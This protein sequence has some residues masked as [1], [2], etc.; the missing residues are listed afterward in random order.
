MK[1]YICIYTGTD[2]HI[3]LASGAKDQSSTHPNH[4]IFNYFV[5]SGGCNILD[6]FHEPLMNSGFSLK[7]I[8]SRNQYC[9]RCG[10]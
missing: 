10:P 1:K 2:T 3:Y 9:S 4:V 6:F 8:C 7:N 5:V